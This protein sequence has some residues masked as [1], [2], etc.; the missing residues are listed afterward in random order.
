MIWNNPHPIEQDILNE[1][2][3]VTEELNFPNIFT[4]LQ[5]EW[6]EDISEK[7]AEDEEKKTVKKSKLP[8]GVLK[9]LKEWR[10]L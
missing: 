8:P 1:Q 4:Q 6:A 5:E 10:P 3:R 7:M 9:K 2:K